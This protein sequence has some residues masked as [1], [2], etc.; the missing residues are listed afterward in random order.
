[1]VQ[2]TYTTAVN[3]S[4]TTLQIVLEAAKPDIDTEV[5]TITVV[6]DQISL[7]KGQT[8]TMTANIAP[9]DADLQIVN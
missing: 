9:I 1:V 4:A 6:P 5:E 7:L 3:S 2:I 8:A